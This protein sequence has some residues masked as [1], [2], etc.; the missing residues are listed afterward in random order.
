M[1]TSK[2]T[3][4][5]LHF[6][7]IRLEKKG[8]ISSLVVCSSRPNYVSIIHHLWNVFFVHKW[9]MWAYMTAKLS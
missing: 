1:I 4:I 9:D 6:S 8:H 2:L 3:L 7:D 5:M